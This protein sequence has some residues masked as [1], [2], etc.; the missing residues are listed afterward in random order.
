MTDSLNKVFFIQDLAF[1]RS[2]FPVLAGKQMIGDGCFSYVFE[3]TKK[4][5]VLKLTCDS[6]YAEFI[7]LKGGEFG[8]PKLM[9]DYGSVYTELYGEVFLF[10]IER[11]RPLSKW[12]HDGMIL[13]RD[14][15]SSAV[16]Y[17][18]ALSEIES[19][20]MP[21]QVAHAAALDEVRMS[22]IFSDS[23]SSALSA[24]AEYMKVTDL[25]VLLDLQNPDNFMTNGRHLI[26]TDP[27]QSVT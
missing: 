15:I 17:K 9:N 3:G 27:L 8:I 5:T 25:D 24:I 18:V 19:G 21:C 4:S 10:E 7:R 23:A 26:I 2:K 1:Y 20:L 6:V 22:G 12:D 16:S 11:L 13:E 14:A